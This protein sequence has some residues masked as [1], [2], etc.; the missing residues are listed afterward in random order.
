[1]EI[2]PCG[3]FMTR[4][5]GGRPPELGLDAYDGH[6]FDCA[7]GKTHRYSSSAVEV[8][9]QLDRV[10][11]G[12]RMV[13]ACPVS[14][15]VTCVKVKGILRIKGFESL[16]GCVEGPTEL[17]SGKATMDK[18]TVE[19]IDV[20]TRFTALQAI[21]AVIAHIVKPIGA[22]ERVIYFIF[23]ET[24][25]FVCLT[26]L[27]SEGEIESLV[28]DQVFGPGG[29]HEQVGVTIEEKKIAYGLLAIKDPNAIRISQ[30]S[31]KALK[32]FVGGAG[33]ASEGALSRLISDDSLLGS[34]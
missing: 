1:M 11:V 15:A 6:F 30:A 10:G 2:V 14:D 16:F 29:L 18:K 13:F 25:Y 34:V 9:R 26:D 23:F 19:R 4:T 8:I 5:T 27:L 7:C 28:M 31:S 22:R 21:N 32:A 17:R 24:A 3:E 20:L 33:E 12:M